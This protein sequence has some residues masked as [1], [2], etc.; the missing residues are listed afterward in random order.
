MLTERYIINIQAVG[1]RE[2]AIHT[3]ISTLTHARVIVCGV[4]QHSHPLRQTGAVLKNPE[5]KQT[6]RAK[7]ESAEE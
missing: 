1:G 2:L 5:T 3:S 4:A 7:Q 6:Q